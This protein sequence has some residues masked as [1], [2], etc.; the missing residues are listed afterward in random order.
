MNAKN[1]PETPF[2]GIIRR[3]VENIEIRAVDSESRTFEI[4]CSSD[5]IDSHGDVVKQNFNLKR[6]KKNPVV[7]FLHNRFGYFDG[8][9][10]EDFLPVGHSQQVRIEDGSLVARF[11]I[12]KGTAEQEPFVDKLWRRIEQKALRAA[13]IGFVPG[14]VTEKKD[15][16]GGIYYELDQNDLYEISLVPIPSN[17]DSVGKMAAMER[18][19]LS[20]LA[21][22]SAPAGD[23]TDAKIKEADDA[24][25]NFERVANDLKPKAEAPKPGVLGPA[26]EKV[27]KE[28][29]CHAPLAPI[30]FDSTQRTSPTL[31]KALNSC[32]PSGLE[33]ALELHGGAR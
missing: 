30:P 16:H 2:D 24:I 14:V 33:I 6:Y 9:R 8:A 15:P 20:S 12:I 32:V 19:F 3:N 17:P 11:H 4:V 13:S 5:S 23:D 21:A 31:S 25:Q 18:D 1:E 26:M 29:G 7:L 22:K 28:A 27:L 10:P